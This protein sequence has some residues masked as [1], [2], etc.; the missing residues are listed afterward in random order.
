MNVSPAVDAFEDHASATRQAFDRGQPMPFFLHNIIGVHT[1]QGYKLRVPLG[2]NSE[3]G[4]AFASEVPV[5]ATA[6]I[7]STHTDAAVAAAETATADAMRQ[8]LENGAKPSG[9][10]FFDCVAT[11]LRLGQEFRQELAAVGSA[12]EGAKFAGFNS[13]GQ[14]VRADGQ[15]S[16]FH[17]C[18]AVVCVFPD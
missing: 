8:V 11:R 18:T 2:V 14:I 6:Q 5:G 3:G 16:G 12:L 7:M 17:N 4:V 15:L 1:E 9:A 10:L 13:Y